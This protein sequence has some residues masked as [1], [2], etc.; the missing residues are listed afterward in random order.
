M[1]P[2][3]TLNKQCIIAFAL[4]LLFASFSKSGFSTI[5]T[6]NSNSDA[7]TGSGTSGTLRWCIN[8][9][10]A[11]AATPHLVQFN[12][13]SSGV[14]VIT[15]TSALPT[16]TRSNVTIDGYT[17]PGA[18]MGPFN[19]RVLTV[20][21]NSD[22]IGYSFTI[23]A[24]NILFRGFDLIET[25]ADGFAFLSVG[26]KFGTVAVNTF[27]NVKIQGNY[28]NVTPTGNAI[29][30][31]PSLTGG[32]FHAYGNIVSGLSTASNIVFG[33]DGDGIDD[34]K[35]GNLAPCPAK[36]SSL[37][38]L[39]DVDNCTIAGNWVGI[40]PDGMTLVN[41]LPGGNGATGTTNYPVFTANA[42]NCVIGTN[43][44]GISDAL[45]RNVI[46]DGYTGIYIAFN[47]TSGTN[48]TQSTQPLRAPGNNIIAG[49][50]VGTYA[51]GKTPA[52]RFFSTGIS[53][54]GLGNYVG[55]NKLEI[56]SSDL[57]NIVAPG[58]NGVGIWEAPDNSSSWNSV[59]N[60]IKGNYIGIGSD[61]TS[62]LPGGWGIVNYNSV[63][64]KDVGNVIG[65]MS[66][67]GIYAG[68]S[69]ASSVNNNGV[70]ITD[71]IIGLLPNAVTA[72][73]VSNDGIEIVNGENF[74]IRHNTIS[75]SLTYSGISVFAG[76][77]AGL[78]TQGITISENN[79][80]NNAKLSIDLWPTASGVTANDGSKGAASSTTSPNL[81]M[82]YPILTNAVLSGNMLTL[83]GYIGSASGQTIFG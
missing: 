71:N 64:S 50:F 65:N 8:Q 2:S 27:S 40:K 72:A 26:V 4:L 78:K 39:R 19:S 75:N 82:D 80:Y 73:P 56:T 34:D 62:A 53:V 70:Q 36:S 61:G 6:V 9:V 77:N 16:L 3:R 11:D 38:A 13:A 20:Q 21:I 63:N 28:I 24:S 14:Q 10:N 81:L 49:N 37:F 57:R 17:E 12:I 48:P 55:C 42:F 43:G 33:V 22:N 7:N 45:E 51:D 44:D 52:N 76:V 29:T 25:N 46:A 83:S 23:A 58:S 18:V 35:E 5:Y 68:K 74:L 1:Y 30:P 32:A 47:Y 66:A 41:Y 59:T 79:I 31:T 67:T 15:L 54:K 60:V 69:S